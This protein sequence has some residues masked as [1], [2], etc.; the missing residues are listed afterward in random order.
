MRAGR[1]R[2]ARRIG[3]VALAACAFLFAA[4]HL[5]VA[6]KTGPPSAPRSLRAT[7]GN[8]RA[9]V[10]WHPPDHLNGYPV[11]R[12][13]IVAYN[14]GDNPLPT[15]EFVGKDPIYVY[16]GLQ[17]GKPYTFTVAAKNRKGWSLTSARSAAVRVG[18]PLAPGKP[19]AVPGTARATVSWK[20][21]AGNGATVKAYRVTTIVNGHAGAVRTYNSPK[22]SQVITGLKR[23]KRY[24]FA[25]AAHNNRG[26]SV[27]S[28]PSAAIFVK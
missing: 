17:N 24:T 1:T 22:T 25:V 7:P 12:W 8:A 21:P 28:N 27:L 15:R 16:P 5:A 6:A 14:A 26:W 10:R 9:T 2:N 18:V 23:G 3:A 20:T 19:T 11:T 13:R 4:P